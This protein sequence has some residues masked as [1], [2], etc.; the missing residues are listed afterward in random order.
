MRGVSK[1]FGGTQALVDAGID[2]SAGE[3]VA[4]LG[5]NGAGKSAL[6]KILAGVHPL[7]AGAI[8]YRGRDAT[9]N[10]RRLPSPFIQ[11]DLA[12][13]AGMTVAEDIAL[14]LG[15]PRRAGPLDWTAR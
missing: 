8:A 14:M 3:I 15:F 5:E 13:I 6:I 2:V 1:H 7:D 9:H 10:P 4:R 12:L 11:Q